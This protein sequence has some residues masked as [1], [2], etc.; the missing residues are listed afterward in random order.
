MFLSAVQWSVQQTFLII[1]ITAT[2]PVTNIP[3]I[4]EDVKRKW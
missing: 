3:V 1:K 2:V 4:D